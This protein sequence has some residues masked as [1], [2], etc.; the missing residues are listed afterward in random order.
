MKTESMACRDEPADIPIRDSD[1][2]VPAETSPVGVRL[3]NKVRLPATAIAK[4]SGTFDTPEITAANQELEN[5][6]YQNILSR[7]LEKRAESASA[8]KSKDP[9]PDIPL[10]ENGERTI[11]IEPGPETEQVLQDSD[12]AFRSLFGNEAYNRRKLEGL[13]E[14]RQSENPVSE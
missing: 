6:F 3:G 2:V 11:T 10:D 1:P 5:H 4:G 12:E 9:E 7:E 14:V 13:M 8:K